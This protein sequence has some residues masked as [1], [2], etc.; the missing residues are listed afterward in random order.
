MQGEVLAEKCGSGV[1]GLDEI[2]G[3]GLPRACLYLVEGTPG[4]GKTTLAL[5]FLL[6]GVRNGERCLYVTLSETRRELDTVARSHGWSLEGLDLIELSD[7][8]RALAGKGKSTLFQAGDLELDDLSRMLLARV[9]ERKPQR[10]VI[11]SLSEL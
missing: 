5:Q 6:E 3:G 9:G 7:V 2:L 10:V 1:R 4:V 8:E 11:D